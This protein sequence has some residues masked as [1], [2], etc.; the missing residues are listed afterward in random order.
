MLAF[1]SNLRFLCLLYSMIKFSSSTRRSRSTDCTTTANWFEIKGFV[2]FPTLLSSVRQS[3]LSSKGLVGI[4]NTRKV[5]AGA[6]RSSWRI[7][8][9]CTEQVFLLPGWLSFVRVFS[10]YFP[11]SHPLQILLTNSLRLWCYFLVL[12][13]SF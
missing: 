9:M 12:F 1:V 10:Y 6:A 3:S 7:H 8:S 11:H 13:Q 5:T 4:P 2:A